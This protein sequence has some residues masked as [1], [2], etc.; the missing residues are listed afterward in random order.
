MRKLLCITFLL[1]N[2]FSLLGQHKATLI[3]S[4]A[5]LYKV[6][7]LLYRSEQ[8]VSEDK[9]VIQNIPI[10]SIINLRYFTRSGD[11]KVFKATDG[12]RLINHPLLTWRIKAPEIA[13]TLKLIKERQKEGAV[14][15]HCYH[16]ADRTGIMV[17]MYRIIYHNWTIE[18]AKKE[19]INGPYGY[20]SVWKNLEALFTESTVNE[21]RRLL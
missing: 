19:M 3:H 4:D 8:L 1:L 20:H 21:V 2:F 13:A 12:V 11:K 6:D 15:I 9:A 7:S 16:G 10:K 5:N 14:L 18:Q 17:A